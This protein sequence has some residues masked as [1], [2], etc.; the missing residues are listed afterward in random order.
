MPAPM[1]AGRLSYDEYYLDLRGPELRANVMPAHLLPFGLARI[2]RP[3]SPS[4][5]HTSYAVARE[6]CVGRWR[7][8]TA[9]G[10]KE[11]EPTAMHRLGRWRGAAESIPTSERREE[12][13]PAWGGRG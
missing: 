2:A 12:R 9:G 7:P 10:L 1:F 5:R 4:H 13:G 11:P 6:C 3:E 8:P